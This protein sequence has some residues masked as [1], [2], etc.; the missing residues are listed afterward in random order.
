MDQELVDKRVEIAR[1][2]I[3]KRA[4]LLGGGG[5]AN[6]FQIVEVLDVFEADKVVEFGN[7]TLT[8]KMKLKVDWLG[9]TEFTPYIGSWYVVPLPSH[10]EDLPLG[11]YLIGFDETVI[12]LRN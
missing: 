9:R 12:P 5:L 7:A 6:E 11:G 2:L 3:G 10:L 4:I 1:A 8:H